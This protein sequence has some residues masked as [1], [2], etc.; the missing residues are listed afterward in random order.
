[1]PEE[2]WD[3]TAPNLPLAKYKKYPT[4]TVRK[5]IELTL[6]NDFWGAELLNFNLP[7]NQPDFLRICE[8]AKQAYKKYYAYTLAV[9]HQV[10]T[11]Q[12]IGADPRILT[13]D[14]HF[15]ANALSQGYATVVPWL[16]NRYVNQNLLKLI[17]TEIKL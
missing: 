5:L 4:S 11:Y 13:G 10:K 1:V 7:E 8:P 2:L 3:K 9:D 16:S 17:G 14:L 12:K 6:E 15:D